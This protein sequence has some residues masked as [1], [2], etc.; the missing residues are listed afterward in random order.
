MLRSTFL[1]GLAAAALSAPAFAQSSPAAQRIFDRARTASGGLAAWNKVAGLNATGTEGGKP[2]KRQ[3][4]PIRYGYRIETDTPKGRLVQG[5]NGAGEWRVL[6]G[7]IE[8]GS[9]E[10]DILT[11]VRS[12]AFFAGF[13]YFFPS[14]FDL[15]SDLV[16]NRQISGKTYEVV[17]VQPAG[18]EAR[19]LWFD[20]K[21]GLPAQ[22][23]DTTPGNPQRVE[24][25]DW[26]KVGAVKLP[27]K[28]VA[29]GGGLMAPRERLIQTVTFEAVDRDIFSLPRKA[30]QRL[31]EPEAPVRKLK[32]RRPAKRRG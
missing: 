7:G 21:T 31:E 8:T 24:Y 27:H 20:P 23:V 5:Y 6:P 18:G 15:K 16:G 4:D 29:T 28:E 32:P 30:A 2:F 22:M 26:R 9:I 17:R 1:I 13:Y 14:R 11:R 12:D 10:R 25:S 3:V 19:E